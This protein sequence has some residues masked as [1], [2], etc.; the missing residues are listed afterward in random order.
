[1]SV[2][3]KYLGQAG[4]HVATGDLTFLLDPW[5]GSHPAFLGTWLAWPNNEQQTENLLGEHVDYVWCSHAHDD[6]F[7]PKYL[8]NFAN[9]S[10][11]LQQDF[12]GKN[13]QRM[14]KDVGFQKTIS[15]AFNEIQTVN[16]DTFFAILSEEPIYSEHALFVLNHRGMTVVHAGDS[17]LTN[18][19]INFIIEVFGSIDLLF[20]QYCNPSPFPEI[21][22]QFTSSGIKKHRESLDSFIAQAKLS[23]ATFVVPFAGPALNSEAL[24]MSYDLALAKFPEYDVDA[25]EIYLRDAL[26]E[27]CPMIPLPGADIK[28]REDQWIFT[29]G[30]RPQWHNEFKKYASVHRDNC[31]E[32]PPLS[33]SELQDIGHSILINLFRFSSQTVLESKVT[34]V[35]EVSGQEDCLV[36][37][38]TEKNVCIRPL[39]SLDLHKIEYYKIKVK[40][41]LLKSFADQVISFDDLSFS[42]L[43]QIEQSDDG[44][45]YRLVRALKA[46]HDQSLARFVDSVLDGTEQFLEPT[47]FF[48]TKVG[49]DTFRIADR[50]P[51]QG[52]RLNP[53]C[54][55]EQ[56]RYV[57]CPLHGWKF[58]LATG[59]CVRGDSRA[60]LVTSILEETP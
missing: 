49:G 15:I 9:S 52:A 29:Q 60:N 45:D 53:E 31:D 13:Y 2:T 41:H 24:A 27:Q 59:E 35:F 36:I 57:T 30:P 17:V 4:L 19:H 43:I 12:P 7:D 11:F 40:G 32:S 48:D 54:V 18:S 16:S 42:R 23:D 58:D 10:T 56:G 47:G 39:E 21:V 44:Y 22:P 55:D 1:M 51:H 6:H 46:Y 20:S 8:K 33:A 3:I 34:L 50:C 26:G 28:I 14:V 25:S 37:A 5:C 38:L